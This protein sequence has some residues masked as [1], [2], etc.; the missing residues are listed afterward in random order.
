MFTNRP[1]LR[2]LVIL[3]AKLLDLIF[4]EKRNSVHRF[5]LFF[6][7]VREGC[8]FPAGKDV[9]AAG[10][11]CSSEGAEQKSR[12]ARTSLDKE[13]IRSAMANSRGD[14]IRSPELPSLCIGPGVHIQNTI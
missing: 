13:N 7:D 3:A 4:G 2:R 1:W 8:G 14:L 12:E 11:S 10:I 6:L 5:Y 9:M